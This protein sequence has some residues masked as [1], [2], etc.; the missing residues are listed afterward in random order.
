MA[1]MEW[2]RIAGALAVSGA[3]ALAAG[4]VAAQEDVAAFYKGKTIDLVIGYSAGGGYDSYARLVAEFLPRHIPGNPEIVPQNMPG[5]SSRKA[6]AYVYNVAD[7]DGT[8][9]ATA[10]QS[11][12]VAQA[13]GEA[14]QLDA[15]QFNYIGSPVQENNVLVTWHTSGVDSID[16][17]KA[18]SV[19]I[20]ATGGSTSSQY[21][22]LLNALAG[23][24][25]DIIAGYPGGNEINY[26]MENGEVA[27]R[28]SVNWSSLKPLG[29]HE[30]GLINVL[31]QIGLS[32]AEDLPEVPLLYELGETEDDVKLMRLISAPTA[33]GRPI[34]TTPEVPEARVAAL[35]AAFDAMVEDPEFLAAAEARGLSISPVSGAQL[36]ATVDEIVATPPAL[37]DRLAE[38]IG[39]E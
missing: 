26:A 36:Q 31:V 37:A 5:A 14:L 38:F 16:A 1:R 9:L 39:R 34:F 23:T 8:V 27:G 25:F 10:D 20:G 12:A 13:M 28:G 18:A 15:S 32:K 21:P 24:K 11:L 35:R 7:R 17:A 30:Q 4:G 19:P 29:W 6:A 2:T 22:A 33:I 3:C